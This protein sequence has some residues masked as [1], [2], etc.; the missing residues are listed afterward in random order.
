MNDLQAT[1]GFVGPRRAGDAVLRAP[2]RGETRAARRGRVPGVVR[3]NSGTGCEVHCEVDKAV[4]CKWPLHI[5]VDLWRRH[6][7]TGGILPDEGS[8]TC[9]LIDAVR[10]VVDYRSLG[11]NEP[12]NPQCSRVGRLGNRDPFRPHLDVNAA[13]QGRGCELEGA[14]FAVRPLSAEQNT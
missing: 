13:F 8:G 7:V 9:N 12:N 6:P 5:L 14:D 3:G 2:G 4:S 10:V 11:A 1:W